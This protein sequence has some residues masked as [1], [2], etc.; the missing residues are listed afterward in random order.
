MTGAVHKKALLPAVRQ[1]MQRVGFL[2]ICWKLIRAVI[3]LGLCYLVLY[4]FLVKILN[5]FKSFQDFLDPTVILLPKH[6]TMENYI[7]AYKAMD[8]PVTLLRTFLVSAF[9]CVLQTAVSAMV[10]YG[11]AR[12]RFR[13]SRLMFGCVIL[14][15]LIP[16]QTLMLSL[17]ETFRQFLGNPAWSLIDTYWPILILSLTGQGL[18]N[19]LY[20]FLFRQFFKNMPHELEEAAYIDGC[21]VPRTFAAV[22]LPSATSIIV[23]VSL[24]SFS[25]QWTDQFYNEL[26]FTSNTV[27][28]NAVLLTENLHQEPVLNSMLQN[29]AAVMAV[30]PLALL[31]LFAQR[32]FVQSVERSGLVG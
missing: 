17:F 5:G 26:F 22:M 29:V 11:F 16:P 12:F 18:R 20:V 24:F 8:Y 27:M 2:G 10:G 21:G 25:W 30:A 13:G 3:L 19:G 14:A 32:F 15:L 9:C 7:T 28:A 23:T 4:P 1:R 31:Y 6:P